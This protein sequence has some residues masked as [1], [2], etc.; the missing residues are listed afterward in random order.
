MGKYFDDTFSLP[1]V[2]LEFPS[3]SG[4]IIDVVIKIDNWFIMIEKT[5]SFSPQK[6][7]IQIKEQYKRSPG[8]NAGAEIFW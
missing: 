5:R 2:E 4:F 7:K 1:V 3:Q 8:S 6:R